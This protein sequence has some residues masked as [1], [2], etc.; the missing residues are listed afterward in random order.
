MEP[1]VYH[2]YDKLFKKILTLSSV[3][4]V[5]LINGLFDT[6]YPT[7]STI[8]YNWT[9]FEKEDMRKI[10]AD[11]ILTI[12]GCH[13]YHMEAQME[14]DE[15]I[16]LCRSNKRAIKY[17]LGVR[18][19]VQYKDERLVRD[20]KLMIVKN[21]YQ[22]LEGIEGMDYIANGDIAKL[23][24]ISKFEERYGLH[25][26]EARISFPDYDD[27]EIVA[28]V[29]LDTLDS[30]SASL[31]YE[32]SNMLYQGVNEDYAHITT[33]KKRY[34]A[35]REDKYYNALQLKYANAITCHKS[36]GG[37]WRC[38]FIDNP[39]WQEELTVDDLK[40]LYTAITRATE[41]VYLV[42]FKDELFAD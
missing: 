37:Q 4:V 42:N 11:T 10:L 27:Q 8:T 20:D 30:E 21:C 36:Q 29:I 31:T 6:D 38:V 18:S 2:I 25:F 40:W 19:T 28:K 34:E 26:A 22:F 12:N 7:D 23:Q 35:V 32:Q 17:N 24:K 33:K 3:A 15:T 39:I 5:N 14:E 1:T 13:S 9:E 16:I 41:K